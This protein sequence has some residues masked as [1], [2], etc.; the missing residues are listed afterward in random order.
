MPKKCQICNVELVEG[1][2]NNKYGTTEGKKFISRHHLFPQRFKQLF[3]QEELKKIFKIDNPSETSELC[4]ECHEE[5]IHNIVLNKKILA[6]LKQLLSNCD[7]KTKIKMFHKILKAGVE[8]IDQK[9]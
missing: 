8:D 7:K 1:N 2:P 4:Y 5:I 9:I 6:K 3:S